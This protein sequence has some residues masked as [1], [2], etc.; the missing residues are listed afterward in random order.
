MDLEKSTS[1]TA[2]LKKLQDDGALPNRGTMRREVGGIELEP[3]LGH[4]VVVEDYIS[5]GFLPLREGPGRTR[6]CDQC[7][8]TR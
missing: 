1:T 8:C 7:E 3:I 6:R 2:S 4:M 5:C